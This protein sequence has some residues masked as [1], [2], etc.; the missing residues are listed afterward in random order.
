VGMSGGVDSSVTALLLKEQGHQV[1]GVFMKNW[2]EDDT[3]TYCAAS[4]DMADAQAV[5]DKLGIELHRVNF[6]AE[7]WEAVFSHFLIEYRAGRTPNPDILC[8]KEIKFK[9]FLNYAKQRGADYIATGHYAR[10]GQ[11]ADQFQ[12]LK[13]CDDQKDQSYFLYALMQ[14]QLSQS[15]FPIGHMEKTAVRELAAKANLPN[16]QKKDSTGI[17]FIGE[18]KFKDFLNEYLPAQP[19]QIISVDGETI[20]THDGLMFYT[21]GQRQGLKIGGIKD[22]AESP[23]YV[24]SKDIP[25]N[26]LIVAQGADHPSLFARHLIAKQVHWINAEP[27]EFPL[28]ISAKTRYRQQDQACVIMKSDDAMQTDATYEMIFD[29]PQRAITPGQSVVFYQDEVC[30][31][32]GIIVDGL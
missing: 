27:K 5:C 22:S 29:H 15:L 13:G 12:L 2:E 14:E 25:N 32:G 31:G 3:D 9:A 6:A 20:G 11:N 21:I 28:Q 7:Y 24:V 26:N 30:L 17:C 19:G 8:N 23:W 1:E 4:A 10:I 18:R 16:H